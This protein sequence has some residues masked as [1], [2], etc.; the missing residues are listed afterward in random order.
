[1]F[2]TMND[3]EDAN[4]NGIEMKDGLKYF[5]ILIGIILFFIYAPML[6]MAVFHHQ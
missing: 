6:Y 4:K 5:F 3:L 2:T 1:M